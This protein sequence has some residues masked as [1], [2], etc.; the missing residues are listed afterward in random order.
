M[1][2]LSTDEPGHH[3][4]IPGRL[5]GEDGGHAGCD[6][7]VSVINDSKSDKSNSFI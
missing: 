2:D 5:S 6:V 7:D 4:R 3:Q 1:L